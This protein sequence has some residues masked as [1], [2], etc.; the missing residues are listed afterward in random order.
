VD[1]VRA[2]LRRQRPDVVVLTGALLDPINL[3]LVRHLLW[4]GVPTVGLTDVADPQTTQ[5]LQDA[6]YAALFPSRSSPTEV[7]DGVRRLLERRRL[8]AAHGALRRERGD[9]RGARADRPDRAGARARCSSRG[10]AA[11]GKELVARAIHRSRRGRSQAVHRG[12]RRRAPRDAARERA[13]RHEKGAF[14]G[15]AER[16][17]GRFELA[18]TARSSSTRSA[19]SRPPRR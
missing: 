16:R 12:E 2:E 18:D 19:R 5:R 10:R 4:D 7:A 6:G 11:P 13:V 8:G 15:A 3:A 1:D 17:L 9:P 14:T